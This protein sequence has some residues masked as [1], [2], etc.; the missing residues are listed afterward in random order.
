MTNY[1]NTRIDTLRFTRDDTISET[2]YDGLNNV[3]QNVHIIRSAYYC[4]EKKYTRTHSHTHTNEMARKMTK[5][6]IMTS[7]ARHEKFIISFFPSFVFFSFYIYL[8]NWVLAFRFLLLDMRPNSGTRCSVTIC[9][10]KG[11]W[12][13]SRREFYELIIIIVAKSS[14]LL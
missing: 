7:Y 6:V 8:R 1:H 4:L 14:M 9:E 2:C 3:N 12:G 11:D 5:W 10:G 13:K